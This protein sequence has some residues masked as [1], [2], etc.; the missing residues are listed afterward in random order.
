M[1]PTLTETSCIANPTRLAP[2][3][4]ALF[5]A[6]ALL[7]LTV[8]LEPFLSLLQSLLSLGFG[9]S[10]YSYAEV[11]FKYLFLGTVVYYTYVC[12]VGCT[13]TRTW[14]LVVNDGGDT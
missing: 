5:S 14:V 11:L 6:L 13:R 2:R 10:S 8:E 7:W 9:F 3:C 4:S 1:L 12:E